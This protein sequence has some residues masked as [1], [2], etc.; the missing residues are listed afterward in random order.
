MELNQ[1]TVLLLVALSVL[2]ILKIVVPAMWK[3][4][5]LLYKTYAMFRNGYQ[6]KLPMS[7]T[8][9]NLPMVM[10]RA[11]VTNFSLCYEY[12]DGF[13]F[14]F[15][16]NQF[17]CATSESKWLAELAVLLRNGGNGFGI[18]VNVPVLPEGADALDGPE[19]YIEVEGNYAIMDSRFP[20][21]DNSVS[22]E[23]VLV[24]E[25]DNRADAKFAHE[26][27]AFARTLNRYRPEIFAFAIVGGTEVIDYI[28]TAQGQQVTLNGVS[29][30]MY[31]MGAFA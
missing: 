26:I 1:F 31:R 29:A 12:E 21:S 13:Y 10:Y 28:S 18:T 15:Q 17:K 20:H 5:A 9:W 7:A 16:R 27:Y 25:H 23:K 24:I 2:A 6:R 19:T 22:V 3:L 8:W 11:W 30:R 4:G 14:D